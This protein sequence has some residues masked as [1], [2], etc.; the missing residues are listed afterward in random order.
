MSCLQTR[1]RAHPS[2]EV[3][4]AFQFCDVIRDLRLESSKLTPRA[5]NQGENKQNTS[6]VVRS[7]K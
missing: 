6:D 5:R 4:A 2:P 1:E 7:G 3:E